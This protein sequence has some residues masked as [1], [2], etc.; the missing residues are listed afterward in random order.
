M[1]QYFDNFTNTSLP[2][3]MRYINDSATMGLFGISIVATVWVLV[4]LTGYNKSPKFSFVTA[5]FFATV[6][7]VMLSFMGVL[8]E[9]FLLM[10]IGSFLAPLAIIALAPSRFE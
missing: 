10:S 6:T 9:Y 1:V 2:G 3:A 5:G 7:A 8:N 4:V